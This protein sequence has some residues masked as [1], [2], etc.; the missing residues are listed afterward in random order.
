MEYKTNVDGYYYICSGYFLKGTK[1]QVGIG[2]KE[3]KNDY[4]SEGF[5]QND[6]LN[7]FGRFISYN[8]IK[9]IGEFKNSRLHG[10]G[11]KVHWDGTIE[12]GRFENNKF[13]GPQ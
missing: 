4:I 6:H 9:L 11:K 7:A 5:F 2:R 13:R 12:E 8:G 1:Q 3:G 10:K